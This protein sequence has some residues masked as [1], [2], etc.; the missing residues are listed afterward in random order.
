MEITPARLAPA[1]DSN[2]GETQNPVKT[3]EEAEHRPAVPIDRSVTPDYLLSLED[4]R[5]YRSLRRH[6]MARHG[7]TP[8]Q[9]RQKWG[10][11]ADYPMVAP[12]YARQR[13]EVAKR[14]GLGKNTAGSEPNTVQV[15]VPQPSESARRR[16]ARK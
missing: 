11:P 7:L 14:I 5:P 12:N 3:E 15:P 1:V 13:S 10:L 6:L 8:D 9:Y 2:V 4:G 16:R